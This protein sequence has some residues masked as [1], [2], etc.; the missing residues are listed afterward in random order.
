MQ[1]IKNNASTR[2]L[3][4]YRFLP[5]I[6]QGT[7]AFVSQEAWI[8]NATLQKNVLF[9]KPFTNH[10]YEEVIE[11]CALN[12]DLS[13]LPAG[14]QTEIGEKVTHCGQFLVFSLVCIKTDK[15]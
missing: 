14:D 8:Q 2:C 3:C 5:L 6:L 13:V 11:S 9:D 15:R 1:E 4:F 10:V 7:T 12:A